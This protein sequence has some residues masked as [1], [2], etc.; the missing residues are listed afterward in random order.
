MNIPRQ[1]RSKIVKYKRSKVKSRVSTRMEKH[2]LSTEMTWM[3]NDVDYGGKV[4]LTSPCGLSCRRLCRLARS[5]FLHYRAL[6]QH[7]TLFQ[8]CK[9]DVDQGRCPAMNPHWQG[10]VGTN[11]DHH[12][13][14]KRTQRMPKRRQIK[15]K[16]TGIFAFTE[17]LDLEVHFSHSEKNRPQTWDRDVAWGRCVVFAL[18]LVVITRGL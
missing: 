10:G 7:N 15:V 3:E 4:V 16:S 5:R 11:N 9:C 13:D 1:Q 17:V 8:S 18:L 2:Q 12:I 14:A 6:P